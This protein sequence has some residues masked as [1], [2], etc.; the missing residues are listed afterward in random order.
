[1]N[2]TRPLKISLLALAALLAGHVSAETLTISGVGSMTP[3]AKRLATEYTRLNPGVEVKVINPPLGSSGGLRAMASGKVDIVLA[4]RPPKAN[5]TGHAQPW[6]RTPLVLATNGGRSQGLTQAQIADVYA[7]RKTTWDD[8]QAIRLVMR[9]EYESETATLRKLSP[10][11][12][13]AVAQALQRNDLPI[14]END[15]DALENLIKIPGS[16][17][18][19]SLGLIKASAAKLTL[20][21]IDGVAPN[22]KNMEN[23]RY[24]LVRQFLLVTSPTMRPAVA[25][26]SAW[27]QS[28]TALAI[29][30][31]LDY[32]PQK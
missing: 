16:L 6:L 22:T 13:A 27:L 8:Q 23:G 3:L 11:V 18:T 21:P 28:P 14:A 26:L 10:K 17:G 24:P 29:A 7:G 32:L 4:G 1:M 15:L 9:G 20:L 12:D 30:R 25:A 2:L 31:E 19:T 5:E